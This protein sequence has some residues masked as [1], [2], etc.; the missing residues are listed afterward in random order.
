MN[1]TV[2]DVY[3]P[4]DAYRDEFRGR[5]AALA[6]EKFAELT[7]RS[8]IDVAANR[9]LSAVIRAMD[10][11]AASDSRKR[12]WFIALAVIGFIVA[13][14]VPALW[15]W[16]EPFRALSTDVKGAIGGAA[17]VALGLAVWATTR[18]K[19][20]GA[21]VKNLKQTADAHR[22]TAWAQMA[23]LNALYTWDIS[24]RLIEATVPR[25]KFDDYFSAKRLRDLKRLY[26]WDDALNHDRSV[27]CAQSGV[28]NGNP[29][30][31]VEFLVQSWGSETYTGSIEISWQERERDSEGKWRTVT[32]YQT[33]TASVTK[34]KPVYESR[35]MLIYGNDAAP[36]LS[37][38]RKPSGL[39]SGG[40]FNGIKKSRRLNDLK[41]FS[42][43][44]DDDSQFTLM[45]NEEFETWFHAKNR[46]DEVEF[47]LLFSALAQQQMLKLMKDKESGFGDDFIFIKDRKINRLVPE[48]LQ[49]ALLDMQ[50]SLFYDY[51]WESAAKKFLAFNENYF[52]DLYFA[53]APL[54]AIPLYQQTR[55]H[56]DI[57]KDALDEEGASFWE[58]EAV[59]NYYGD[60][61]LG[62]PESLT[63]NIFKT[64]VLRRHDG[65]SEVEVCAHGFGGV[66]HVEYKTALG[67]DGKYHKV[68]VHWT[69]YVPVT[70]ETILLVGEENLPRKNSAAEVWKGDLR[71]MIRSCIG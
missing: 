15:A 12:S 10:A 50:P 18:A 23:P 1:G 31:F 11:R 53:L 27:R 14:V 68:P 45:A 28:I 69:E 17:A 3:E 13:L 59:A 54:L 5:F 7:E 30:V 21:A 63:R 2:Q 70:Q 35:T 43:N 67:R 47:R 32:R 65:V 34:P 71:R 19:A 26:D 66:E 49:D 33:L 25:L 52:R 62:S 64:E 40:W 20:L 56:E 38:S 60:R 36:K 29:F 58:H 51:D 46:N 41:N 6:Q 4:L 61:R 48:H 39:D 16:F 8:G 55:T 44:L 9:K 42:R 24:N 57:W 37:F 22:K